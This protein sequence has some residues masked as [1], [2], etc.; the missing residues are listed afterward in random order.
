MVEW[1]NK[2]ALG[3]NYFTDPMGN[4]MN[5]EF[6]EDLIRKGI[7]RIPSY[8]EEFYELRDLLFSLEGIEIAYSTNAPSSSGT[9][10]NAADV[11]DQ[12]SDNSLVKCL[13]AYDIL[14]LNAAFVATAFSRSKKEYILSN[15]NGMYWHAQLDG[16]RDP[17]LN[18]IW[19]ADGVNLSRKI[20]YALV[21]VS[22]WKF[23]KMKTI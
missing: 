15:G 9:A 3:T 10:N 6:E 11:A 19:A 5:L 12:E 2:L 21:I 23:R 16:L 8:F 17:A 4:V 7:F 1:G 14:Y 20:S 13:S 18:V 22:S